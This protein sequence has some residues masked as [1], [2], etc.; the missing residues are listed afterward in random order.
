M[1]KPDVGSW[2]RTARSGPISPSS[3]PRPCTRA[4]RLNL[5]EDENPSPFPTV[6]FAIWARAMACTLAKLGA[7]DLRRVLQRASRAWRLEPDRTSPRLLLCSS[8]SKCIHESDLPPAER[9]QRQQYS[10]LGIASANDGEHGISTFSSHFYPSA[11][12]VLFGGCKINLP[13]QST[14]L[15]SDPNAHPSLY[16]FSSSI[17]ASHH[18]FIPGSRLGSLTDFEM[19]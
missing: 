9:Y 17:P 11:P 8:D 18:L 7:G 3:R 19:S 5:R 16:D 10:S 12:R 6:R 1:N 13:D 4:A 2:T 15:L 14:S